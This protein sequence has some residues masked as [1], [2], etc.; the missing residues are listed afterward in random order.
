MDGYSGGAGGGSGGITAQSLAL[1]LPSDNPTVLGWSFD[2]LIGDTTT[3]ALSSGVTAYSRVPLPGTVTVS[4]VITG[5]MAAGSGLTFARAGIYAP[6]GTLIAQTA[7]QSTAWTSTGLKTMALTAEAGQSLTLSVPW[8]HVAILA[9]GTTRPAPIRRNAAG[10]SLD[11]AISIGLT[12]AT[13]RMGY[14]LSQSSLP[15][16]RPTLAFSSFNNAYWVALA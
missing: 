4:S 11:T 13:Y 3:Q 15:A 5:I 12:S 6:D 10:V 9:I 8:V 14:A 2:P 7:D 16:A 1:W